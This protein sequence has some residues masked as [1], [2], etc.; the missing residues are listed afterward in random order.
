VVLHHHDQPGVVQGL[1]KGLPVD[2]LD[3]VSV[4]DPDRDAFLGQ[5][6]VGLQSFEDGDSGPDD[7]HPVV[8]ARAQDLAPSDR[9]VGVVRLLVEDRCLLPGGADEGDAWKVGHPGDQLGRRV[10]IRRIQHGGAVH[11]PHHGQVLQGHLG[12]SVLAD[13]DTGMRTAQLELGPAD[14]RHPDEVVGPR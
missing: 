5:L 11:G 6:V 2:R 12:G 9:E 8:L 1:P 3:R 7:G 14:G 4:D 10:S 13:G